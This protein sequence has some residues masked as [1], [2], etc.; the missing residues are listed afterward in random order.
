[1]T[2]DRVSDKLRDSLRDRASD[3]LSEVASEEEIF[4]WVQD[5]Y[6]FGEGERYGY[7]MPGTPCD[8][9][10]A[11]YLEGKL[12]AF[13]LADVHCEP[14]PL[15]VAFPDRWALALAGCETVPC[16]YIRYAG[17]TPPG[18]VT[19]PL[20][21]VGQGSSAEFEAVDVKGKIVVVDVVADG[22]VPAMGSTYFVHDPD[23]AIADER[24]RAAWP[25]RNLASSYQEACRRN[26]AGWVGVLTLFGDDTHH[27]LH[28]YAQ[29]ELPALTVS[30]AVGPQLRARA[31]AGATAT[32]VLTG[33]RGQGVGY[34]VY[35]LI[36]GRRSDEFIVLKSHYDGWATNEASG[37]AVTLAT[38]AA[39]AAPAATPLER[40]VLVFFRA[41]HF[42][43]GWS[44]GPDSWHVPRERAAAI[45]GLRPD[46]ADYDCLA[47]QL[48]PRTVAVNNIEMVGRRYTREGDAW[49]GLNQPAVRH[50]GV[51]GPEGGANPVLLEAVSQAIVRH[52]LSASQVSNFLVGDGWHYARQGVPLVNF[53]SHNV[54]QFTHKDTL[55]T[56]FKRDLPAAAAAFVDIVR[57]EDAA[58]TQSLRPAVDVPYSVQPGG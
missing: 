13:G 45:Y 3:A 1:M 10:A 24:G 26:A 51:T 48:I 30:S 49:V 20:V 35:G 36:P 40:S 28:W 42:G 46:W 41:S 4:R 25:L 21:Y 31:R 43:V 19:G 56:V 33:S 52:G 37:A 44:L 9:A 7:R 5:L 32:L 54:W 39:L 12:R 17:Y 53:I 6:A 47:N 22:S 14:V 8:H 15:A 18:G 27:Y 38:A 23:G 29:F 2:S 55:E 58:S 57:A 50:W 16:S 34:N 11:R